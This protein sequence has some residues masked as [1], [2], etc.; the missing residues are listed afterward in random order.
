MPPK[1]ATGKRA[2]PKPKPSKRAQ[3]RQKRKLQEAAEAENESADRNDDLGSD[4]E[5]EE[6]DEDESEE[7]LEDDEVEVV[8][9]ESHQNSSD[10]SEINEFFMN[11]YPFVTQDE[12]DAIIPKKPVLDEGWSAKDE[13]RLV[14]AWK[15]DPDRDIQIKFVVEIL[16]MWKACIRFC[17][18]TP[19]QLISKANHLEYDDALN[20]AINRGTM[21]PGWTNGFCTELTHLLYHPFLQGKPGLVVIALQYA[22]IL[23]HKDWQDWPLKNPTGDPLFTRFMELIQ[24]DKGLGTPIK[25]LHQRTRDSL[26]KDGIDP[27]MFSNFLRSLEAVAQ[28]T[29]PVDP[30][31]GFPSHPYKVHRTDTTNVIQ[32]LDGMTHMGGLPTWGLMTKLYN[33]FVTSRKGSGSELPSQKSLPEYMERDILA[34]RREAAKEVNKQKR[35]AGMDTPS[36]P[37]PPEEESLPPQPEMVTVPKA[38]V[39]ELEEVNEEVIQLRREVRDLKRRNFQQDLIK[40]KAPNR[41]S[42]R[43][44]ADELSERDSSDE[45]QTADKSAEQKQDDLANAIAAFQHPSFEGIRLRMHYS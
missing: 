37:R 38:E 31:D 21:R 19:R 25:H 41:G 3:K 17:K 7:E 44:A 40:G 4:E 30:N 39:D 16:K 35:I 32:A 33:S 28:A 6:R 12:L 26:L 11:H 8:E 23:R 20:E 18:L 15:A 42:D 43:S 13:K 45:P 27:G 29:D 22:S 14:K 24:E 36:S 5:E 9:K 2:A 10:F 1:T 34:V